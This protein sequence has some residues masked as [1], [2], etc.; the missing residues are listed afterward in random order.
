MY[1]TALISVCITLWDVHECIRSQLHGLLVLFI[2]FETI[3]FFYDQQEFCFLVFNKHKW[4]T[5]AGAHLNREFHRAEEGE[6]LIARLC[7]PDVGQ[8][9]WGDRLPNVEEHVDQLI[10]LLQTQKRAVLSWQC[11]TSVRVQTCRITVFVKKNVANHMRTLHECSWAVCVH[12]QLTSHTSLASRA[13]LRALFM[14]LHIHTRMFI[15]VCTSLIT[16]LQGYALVR[17]WKGWVATWHGDANVFANVYLWGCKC[18]RWATLAKFVFMC[19][20]GLRN[21]CFMN[22]SH[23]LMT[24]LLPF[25]DKC[26]C[27]SQYRTVTTI[28]F[29]NTVK[30]R[31]Y[32]NYVSRW[33]PLTVW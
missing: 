11:P 4:Y 5:L 28:D 8:L 30:L 27:I 21:A 18:V 14:G 10:H 3:T 16:R 29:A 2:A 6:Q 7:L 1:T 15:R 32:N 24:I 25:F 19:L 33:N 23:S 17:S 22:H 20:Q 26:T 9:F 31:V 12:K 13:T